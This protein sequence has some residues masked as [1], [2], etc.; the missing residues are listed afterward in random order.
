MFLRPLAVRPLLLA[1]ALSASVALP[2]HAE[3]AHVRQ[4]EISVSGEGRASI[5][6]DMAIVTLSVMRQAKTAREATD[7]NSKA[8]A[9]VLEALKKDGI[10]NRDL[11]TAGF[12]I[13]PQYFYPTEPNGQ[14][15]APELTGY[16]VT[17]TLTVRL[18][19]LDKLGAL[20]DQAVDLGVNQGGEI[21]F[22]N[23]DSAATLKAAREAAVK[24]AMEKARTLAEAAG[25]KLGRVVTLT[26]NAPYNEPQP[27]IRAA[28]AMEKAADA[29]VPVAA[30]ENQYAV[31]V[32]AVF[33]IED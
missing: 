18:R 22:D 28:M 24:D 2:L 10:E 4:A 26:E 8:M 32:N 27:M 31:Q 6:P 11:Q 5:A 20:L 14:P 25:V 9:A 17:N 23:S 19:Q 7:E 15:K 16:Q 29:P 3:E 13:Q 21:R 12:S 1:A 33:A 30:G